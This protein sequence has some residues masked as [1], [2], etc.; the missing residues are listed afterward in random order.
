MYTEP[1]YTIRYSSR[2]WYG[3]T[4]C[5][6]MVYAESRCFYCMY[7]C[8]CTIYNYIYIY[9]YR[10]IICA[11]YRKVPVDSEQQRLRGRLP[12]FQISFVNR[13]NNFLLMLFIGNVR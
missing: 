4:R 13:A 6:L 8:A 2:Y 3:F 7:L 9:T 12:T 11:M 10:A 1:G 5:N